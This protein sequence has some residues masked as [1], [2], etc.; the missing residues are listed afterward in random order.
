MKII[1]KLCKTNSLKDNK[2]GDI[3]VALLTIAPPKL[4]IS[5]QIIKDLMALKELKDYLQ[6]RFGYN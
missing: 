5:N 3:S 1:T 6:A 2:K 4:Q